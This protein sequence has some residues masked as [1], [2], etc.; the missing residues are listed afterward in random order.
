MTDAELGRW[1]R[2]ELR[3]LVT[4]DQDRPTFNALTA[5]VELLREADGAL[6]T[7]VGAITQSEWV[8]IAPGSRY[9]INTVL[10]RLRVVLK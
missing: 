4:W 1:L 10:T 8:K 3:S 6:L 5:L 9:T 2:E 7:A